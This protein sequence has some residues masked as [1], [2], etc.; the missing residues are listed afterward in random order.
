MSP[1]NLS[2]FFQL[3]TADN[4]IENIVDH[5]SIQKIGEHPGHVGV[6][7]AHRE[8]YYNNEIQ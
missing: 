6:S 7:G 8:C 1:I 2:S 3:Q 4:L 5:D